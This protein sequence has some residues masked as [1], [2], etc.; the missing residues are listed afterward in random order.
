MEHIPVAFIWFCLWCV[1]GWFLIFI[2]LSQTRITLMMFNVTKFKHYVVWLE[3]LVVVFWPL[4]PL[5][6]ITVA[7]S[8]LR[9]KERNP[10]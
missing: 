4:A 2:R 7:K 6:S 5:I 8:Y 3:I 1:A 9:Y 10:E